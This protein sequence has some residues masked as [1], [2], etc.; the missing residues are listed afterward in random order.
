MKIKSILFFLIL[1]F[2]ACDNKQIENEETLRNKKN[3][4]L[5]YLDIYP[6]FWPSKRILINVKE[7]KLFYLKINKEANEENL[8]PE[9]Q[10]IS[11]TLKSSQV[12]E[13]IDAYNEI[14]QTDDEYIAIPDGTINYINA[15]VENDKLISIPSYQAQGSNNLYQKSLKIVSK[16]NITEFTHKELMHLGFKE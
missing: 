8:F 11:I 4:S 14:I 13:L 6:S 10:N 1:A 16:A 2:L 3:I 12:Q 7:K 15:V 5:I 9:S